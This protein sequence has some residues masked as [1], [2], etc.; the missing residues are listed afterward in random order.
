MAANLQ[1]YSTMP[2]NEA[3]D[4]NVQAKL[5]PEEQVDYPKL[6]KIANKSGTGIVSGAE[7]IEFFAKSGLS[8][9]VLSEI[10][11]I[12]DEAN[13]GQLDNHAFYVALKLIA[14]QQQGKEPSKPII[15]TNVKVPVFDGVSISAVPDAGKPIIQPAEREKF[16]RIFH[17][18]RPEN[19]I[20]D[21]EKA[22]RVF[23][24]SQLPV[25]TLAQIWTLADSRRSGTLNQTEFVIAMYYVARCME[26]KKDLPSTLPS[27]VYAAAAG[28]PASASPSPQIAHI[29]APAPRHSA[30]PPQLAA[31][32]IQSVARQF[33]GSSSAFSPMIS[34]ANTMSPSLP[35]NSNKW[36]ISPEDRKKYDTFFDKID[37]GKHGYIQG[38]DAVEFFQNS[39]LPDADLAHIWDLA[40]RHERGR[41]SK[42]EFAIAMYLIHK[43]L[44]GDA[45]P[46]ILPSS[47]LNQTPA[48]GVPVSE[49]PVFVQSPPSTDQ[50]LIDDGDH[51]QQFET[52]STVAKA[53]SELETLRQN[54]KLGE[55]QQAGLNA[56]R[57]SL[58]DQLKSVQKEQAELTERLN[59]LRTSETDAK[60]SITKLK[61]QLEVEREE[62]RKV[63]ED[64]KQITE[65]L[66]GYQS[67]KQ[68][69]STELENNRSESSRLKKGIFAK[70][71]Q[72]NQL[73]R[74]LE[75]LGAFIKKDRM[76]L[77][78]T[79]KQASAAD[80]D[81]A[82][83]ETALDKA[84]SGV[85]I[86]EVS[87]SILESPKLPQ[88]PSSPTDS[89]SPGSTARRLV[90]SPTQ[91]TKAAPPPPP[92]SSRYHQSVQ[93][94]KR[95]SASLSGKKPP[96]PPP[97]AR[98]KSKSDLSTIAGVSA[99]ATGA[100][101]AGLAMEKGS[102]D[103]FSNSDPFDDF[104]RTFEAAKES[105]V[106]SD[107]D[108]VF[109]DQPTSPFT[110][111]PEQQQ[112]FSSGFDDDFATP[113]STH[114]L[115]TDKAD[116]SKKEAPQETPAVEEI[117]SAQEPSTTSD[118]PVDSATQAEQYEE[119]E[120]DD[121]ESDSPSE[122]TTDSESTEEEEDEVEEEEET[123]AMETAVPTAAAQV[124]S[125]EQPSIE[126]SKEDQQVVSDQPSEPIIEDQKSE[127]LE[128]QP[129]DVPEQ[130][131]EPVPENA[132][133]S[134]P[135]VP[136]EVE[137][138]QE[139]I[140][141]EKGQ[142][143]VEPQQE[144]IAEEK[145]QPEMEQPVTE[146][147]APAIEDSIPM[148]E[149]IAPTTESLSAP[150]T[151]TAST[152]KVDNNTEA[153]EDEQQAP[154][155]LSQPVEVT[156]AD[157]AS[158]EVAPETTSVEHT[159]NNEESKEE[160]QSVDNAFE[161]SS[162]VV[163]DESPH[164]EVALA[165]NP[166]A[167]HV[168]HEDPDLTLTIAQPTLN[169]E[170][171]PESSATPEDKPDHDFEVIDPVS[172]TS[173]FVSEGMTVSMEQEQSPFDDFESAFSGSMSEARVIPGS[174]ANDFEAPFD[175]SF[176][177]DFNPTFEQPSQKAS[178]PAPTATKDNP[179][180]AAAFADSFSFDNNAFDSAFGSSA[181]QT[182]MESPFNVDT[183][184]PASLSDA[185]QNTQYLH[186]G[187]SAF[188]PALEASSIE[189]PGSSSP[190]VPQ[191]T[192]AQENIAPPS[193]EPSS[194]PV[195]QNTNSN[196]ATA[197]TPSSVRSPQ[198]SEPQGLQE[199]L[200]MGFSREQAVDALRRYDNDLEKA[201]NFLLDF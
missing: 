22:R 182:D 44:K 42:E 201:T 142:P 15:A 91:R 128:L 56:E 51:F 81:V 177:E 41:L 78:I 63:Q 106:P 164:E 95:N 124:S 133:P 146:E 139:E 184:K 183:P 87:D 147:Q 93:E 197:V 85:P 111:F 119:S 160:D 79:R 72:S 144:E 86:E 199:L 73:R 200:N 109:G 130:Q 45:L 27:N 20:L 43:R 68:E 192:P 77:D 8:P 134:V 5:S 150:S 30:G 61:E 135:V 98:S 50:S 36:I 70:Q 100:A 176:E 88:L 166:A 155:A 151:D 138:Q 23:S 120:A 156:P 186:S 21:S 165:N 174:S 185:A 74:E 110:S 178:L 169:E 2:L 75:K 89:N 143:E 113:T 16:I 38:G 49:A 11:D 194:K 154:V 167:S 114:F 1:R 152:V 101:A 180:D 148:E 54:V 55:E 40:D 125:L 108:E 14:C 6:F 112:A 188:A 57:T 157:S 12:A 175:A 126:P 33:T 171:V 193:A 26:G 96:A 29:A 69:I 80:A 198:L 67:Q 58:D 158:T 17:A 53:N 9:A 121:T 105:T 59:N 179:T 136:E 191:A 140:A 92:P 66:E 28:R 190:S 162:A 83:L 159:T 99:V 64:A 82:K 103:D 153:T 107:F 35:P 47:L 13:A 94:E 7:A 102:H 46:T 116:D 187:F 76:M 48:S 145:G 19:G 122:S 163:K 161:E 132:E 62:L 168:E 137:S 170:P 60:A 10:W 90:S 65:V 118:V 117:A 84:K 4:A 3:G 97:V 32:P 25:D 149:E 123:P 195:V 37:V 24:R 141:E 131:G 173:S 34:R 127:H 189:S 104:T 71:E 181:H 39:R 31:S 52:R 196:P 129:T 172:S 115:M 18:S